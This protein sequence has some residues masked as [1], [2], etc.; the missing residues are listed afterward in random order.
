MRPLW[1]SALCLAGAFALGDPGIPLNDV[2]PAPDPRVLLVRTIPPRDESSLL[3]AKAARGTGIWE[4]ELVPGLFIVRMAAT[5]SLDDAIATRSALAALP[6]TISVEPNILFR[7]ETRPDSM[8]APE[9]ETIQTATF[10][11]NMV[12]APLAWPLYGKGLGSRVCVLDTGLD[13]AHPSMPAPAATATFVPGQTADDYNF[14]GTH[15]AGTIVGKDALIGSY[16]IAPDASLLAAKVVCD[17]GWGE[18]AWLIEGIEWATLNHAQVISMSLSSPEGSQALEAVCAAAR[19]AGVV[20]VA[21]AG[22]E[23]SDAPHFPAAY[24]SVIAV[25]ALNADKTHASFSNTGAHLSLSAPGVNVP[26]AIPIPASGVSWSGA[27]HKASQLT[28]SFGGSVSGVVIT[29]GDGSIGAIPGSASGKVAHIRRSN[30]ITFAQ[31]FANAVVAGAIGVVISNNQPDSLIQDS[32]EPSIFPVPCVLISQA[33]G[34]S[35]LA[36]AGS[37]ISLTQSYSGHFFGVLTGTS[38][39]TPHVAGVAAL[40]IGAFGSASIS[41]ESI[42]W[43]LEQTAEDVGEPGF[44][45]STGFG[46][47]NAKAAADYFAGRIRCPGDLNNDGLIDD[48]DFSVFVGFYNDFFG[49]GGPWTGGDL[50]GNGVCDDADF[51]AFV[52]GYDGLACP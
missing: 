11:L 18:L 5:T 49:P 8:P 15:C 22:N 14:H 51:V 43:V 37:T 31:Q 23:S 33:D 40:I 34:D 21:A 25:G 42:R 50:D 47:V 52:P 6:C 1:L 17:G 10:N 24:P 16:S 36:A 32:L 46:L 9:Y 27:T 4:S 28:G 2:A 30:S 13:L 29:C 41:P 44:D 20:L 35:L 39:A 12:R 7:I 45:L 19:D 3:V 48:G 38:Q 26:S